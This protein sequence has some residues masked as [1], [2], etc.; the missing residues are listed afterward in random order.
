MGELVRAIRAS[1]CWRLADH[2]MEGD[3]E[4]NCYFNINFNLRKKENEKLLTSS[5]SEV[6]IG[7]NLKF[8]LMAFVNDL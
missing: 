8:V 1:N 4:E 6:K 5:P 3:L 7:L 2:I